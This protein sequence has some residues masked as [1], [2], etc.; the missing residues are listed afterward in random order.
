MPKSS[1]AM[2]TPSARRRRSDSM[3]AGPVWNTV[4]VISSS[5]A[6]GGRPVISRVR[7]TCSTKSLSKNCGGETLMPTRGALPALRAPG[8]GG[9]RRG[10]QYPVGEVLDESG[11][12]GDVDELL[13]R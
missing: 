2:A 12:L 8:R 1:S 6:L 3:V 4:S 7:A 11:L 5:R 10:A 13:G 9:G